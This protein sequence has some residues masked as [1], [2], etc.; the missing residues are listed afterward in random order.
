MPPRNLLCVRTDSICFHA[1]ARLA[2]RV[3]EQIESLR[4]SDLANLRFLYEKPLFDEERRQREQSR[5]APLGS[6]E[7]VFKIGRTK[8]TQGHHAPPV[9][10]PWPITL[11][12][13]PRPAR[14][15]RPALPTASNYARA[16]P[17]DP[18]R[19]E[20]STALRPVGNASAA[21]GSGPAS[22]GLA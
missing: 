14:R 11:A 10:E 2:T 9:A 1:C 5:P 13:E 16:P 4:F 19:R 6:W 18:P 3:T 7:R 17:P 15:P 22:E 20:P 12:P 8:T 21:S